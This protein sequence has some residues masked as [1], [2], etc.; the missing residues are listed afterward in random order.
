MSRFSTA[1]RRL[2]RNRAHADY[3]VLVSRLLGGPAP[4]LSSDHRDV[5]NREC[6]R[7]PGE[8]EDL[9]EMFMVAAA[10]EQACWVDEDTT[11]WLCGPRDV[12]A[13]AHGLSEKAERSMLAGLTVLTVALATV[14]A[15]TDNSTIDTHPRHGT[16][17]EVIVR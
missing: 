9:H 2:R 15:D 16:S 1:M 3:P 8:R 4:E 5:L 14:G 12:L 17:P 13:P 6:D 11:E 7:H 10:A